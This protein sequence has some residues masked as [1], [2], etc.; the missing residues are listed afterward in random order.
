MEDDFCQPQR[1]PQAHDRELE[2]GFDDFPKQLPEKSFF[3]QCCLFL[4]AA[5]I[6]RQVRT[7]RHGCSV[8]LQ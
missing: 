8:F 3:L 6:G 2:Q 4:K 1:P 5:P 7:D